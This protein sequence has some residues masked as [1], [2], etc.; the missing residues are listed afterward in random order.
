MAS[1]LIP[2]V[3]RGNLA[4]ITAERLVMA[5]SLA[6]ALVLQLATDVIDPAL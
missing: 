5:R 2:R 1:R 6:L 3:L 4:S